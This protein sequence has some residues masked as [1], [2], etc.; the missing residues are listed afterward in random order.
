MEE[1]WPLVFETTPGR[2]GVVFVGLVMF[3]KYRIG[4]REHDSCTIFFN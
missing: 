3:V 1:D 4:V 2:I